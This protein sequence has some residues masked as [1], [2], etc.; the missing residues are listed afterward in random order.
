MF[1]SAET[2]RK[3]LV[4]TSANP[5]EGKTTIAASIATSLAQSGKRVL[6]VDTDLRKPRLHRSFDKTLERGITTVLVG[7]HTLGEAVHETEITGLDF[8]AAGPIPPNPSELLHTSQFKA[9]LAEMAGLYDQIV[10]DSP[11]L[12][13]VADAAV[14]APQVDGVI[15][16]VHGQRTSRDALRSALRRLR[17]VGSHVIGGVLNDVDLSA[18]TYGYYQA[19][20]YYMEEQQDPSDGGGGGPIAPQRPVAD[21]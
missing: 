7:E 8:A 9:L 13:A 2:P 5:R 15:V 16:V 10:F 21:A 1:M 4:V 18:G 14:L 17:S 19:G 3:T 12:A 6:L 11:P 20:S